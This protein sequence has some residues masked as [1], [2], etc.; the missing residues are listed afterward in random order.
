M[1]QLRCAA[2]DEIGGW[3]YLVST[4]RGPDSFFN[5]TLMLAPQAAG[6]L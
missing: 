5:F 6:P 3:S 1:V 4:L 2:L